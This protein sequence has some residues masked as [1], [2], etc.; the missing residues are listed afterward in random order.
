MSPVI[1]RDGSKV[2]PPSIQV[3]VETTRVFNIAML[4]QA[5]LCFVVFQTFTRALVIFFVK[6]TPHKV[7]P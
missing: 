1:V 6:F 3:N 7:E 5:K 4:V 2:A